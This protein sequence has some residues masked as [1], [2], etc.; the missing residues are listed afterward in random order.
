MRLLIVSAYF[1]SHRGGI[2]IVAGQLAREFSRAGEDVV[3]LA[4]GTEC[5]ASHAASP[6]LRT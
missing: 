1:D 6:S 3:W 4:S 5:S 2:E